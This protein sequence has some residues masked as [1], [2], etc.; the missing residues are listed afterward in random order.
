VQ[1]VS[2]PPGPIA[3]AV[4]R[5]LVCKQAL[6]VLQRALAVL[7]A[8]ADVARMNVILGVALLDTGRVRGGF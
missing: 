3:D 7:D 1:A 2:E 8:D 4:L 5:S 6:T